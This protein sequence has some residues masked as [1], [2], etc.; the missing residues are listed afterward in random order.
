MSFVLW[1]LN[2]AAVSLSEGMGWTLELWSGTIL[3][4]TLAG[5][6]VSLLAVPPRQDHGFS[7]TAA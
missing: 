6:G 4:A 1:S 2:M 7:R 5:I 3:L